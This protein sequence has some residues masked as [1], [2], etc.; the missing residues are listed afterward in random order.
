MESLCARLVQPLEQAERLER[1]GHR[2]LVWRKILLEPWHVREEVTLVHHPI[3]AL[4]QWVLARNP[5]VILWRG[6]A[7]KLDG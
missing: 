3:K 6:T 5:A 2:D 1:V 4:L 7:F